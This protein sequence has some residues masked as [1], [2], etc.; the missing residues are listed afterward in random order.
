MKSAQHLR[1]MIVLVTMSALMCI[2]LIVEGN[3]ERSQSPHA[4][5]ADSFRAFRLTSSEANTSILQWDREIIRTASQRQ[6]RSTIEGFPL[7][8]DTA[9]D[10]IVEPFSV[11]GPA[12][13]FVLGRK[14]Q[15]D[16]AFSF[17]ATRI[18]FL[19]GK[20]SGQPNSHVFMAL[21][22]RQS[23]GYIDLG[24]GAGRY[25]IASRDNRGR[26]LGPGVISVF[27][28]L[29]TTSQ[30]PAVPFC[31]VQS[32]EVPD[33]NEP[34]LVGL[35]AARG[36]S[37][38]PGLKHIELAV[39][40]D[41]EYF[42]LFN[43][44]D[45]AATYLVQMYGA[46]SDIYI[47]DVDTRIELVFARLWDNPDD[48]FN[49]VDP[50]PLPEFQ[51]YWNANMDA[52]SRD[53]AQ[54]FSGRRDYPFGG[55]AFLSALCSSNGYSVVGYA[56]GFFPDPSMP[57]PFNYDIAV[58]AH[59]IAHN[60]G[61]A[62]THDPPNNI[63]TCNDPGTTPQ[64]GTIM[65]YCGQTWSG[66]N[67][68]R[69]LYFHTTIVQN[70]KDH[71]NSVA[72]VI[73]DCNMNGT[74]DAMDVM[75]T[76]PDVNGNGVPD[77][78][79]DCDDDG[80]LNDAEII[81]GSLDL[82]ANGIPDECEPDCNNNNIPDDKDIADGTSPD[83]YGN[84]IPD[85][86]EP[87]CDNDGTSDYT[88]IQFDM[89][90]DVDRNAVLDS[91]QDCD[92]DST[93]DHEA[94]NGSHNLW[95]ASGEVNTPVREFYASTGVLTKSSNGG[96]G[97]LVQRGQD[98]VIGPNRHVFVTSA[99]DDRVM[100]FDLDGNYLGDF[101]A[102]GI[103]GLDE[104][105]GLIFGPDDNLYVSSSLTNNVL[106]YNGTTGVFIDAFAS[107]GGLVTPFGLIFGRNGNLFVASGSNEVIEYDGQNGSFI[108]VFI[109]AADNGGL[110]Q[111]KGLTFKSDGN[112][113][114]CSFGTNETLEFDGETG[115][116]LGKW[117]QVGTETRL[118]QVSPWGI[119]VGPN[120]N[121]FIVR[122]G[123]DFGSGEGKHKHH[124]HIEDDI[125][126]GDDDGHGLHLT[127]AQIYEFDVRTG[128]FLRTHIG[129]NDHGLLFPT[130]FDFVP[131]WEIDCNL[132]LLPDGCDIASGFSQ[133]G[134]SNN[135]P[136]E[137]DIDC[138]NN[139]TLDRLDIIPFG[140]SFDCNGN[141][142]PDDCDIAAGISL[143][144]TGNGIPDEC[145]PDCNMNSTPDSCDIDGGGSSD[146]NANGIPDDCEPDC[147]EN[148]IPDACDIDVLDPDGNGMVSPDCNS[149]LV[150]DECDL[151]LLFIDESPE[152]SPIHNSSPQSHIIVSP[153]EA[154]SDA[155]LMFEAVADVDS[156]NETID[157]DI[158]GMPIGT[159]F[160]MGAAQCASTHDELIVPAAVFNAAVAGGDATVNLTASNL[161][162][163]LCNPTS[164][165]IILTFE[166]DADCN[167]NGLPDECDALMAGTPDCNGN[168]A[169]DDC[170]YPACLM[171]AAIM[172]G[173]FTCDL[174]VDSQDM[175]G[176]LDAMMLGANLCQ[177]DM[178]AD[179]QVNGEDIP[180]FVNCLLGMCP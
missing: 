126:H 105:T 138:N 116:P 69:D 146:C 68:N 19:R 139:D 59:E 179:M 76:S 23:T 6:G 31:G 125:Y 143:D 101:V 137:C 168:S 180:G 46:V 115:A 171:D 159:V 166:T 74:D 1:S 45:A 56:A 84:G 43:D 178:N 24:N 16:Q 63:D 177:A 18:S 100:E 104:P 36:V 124:D 93:I 14:G 22:D 10:L 96:P 164:I 61:T 108:R 120:G 15:P 97:A 173:D 13:R 32:H 40:T 66:Q 44:L 7:R 78:C 117:A 55:Q 118:T 91:C 5:N 149:N 151:T 65:S 169:P 122:T 102:P 157:V 112:L 64:R 176:F 85:E 67:S 127:N 130:G 41:F 161:V 121:V 12:T 109:S 103:G 17:D 163:N 30:V 141:L 3:G 160:V 54:L 57:S 58:A 165:E 150:P 174:V 26:A 48:L 38:V 49:D 107:G 156:I 83:L 25:Q 86:C 128:N 2:T 167:D 158:N 51:N 144:C 98:L 8:R 90:L 71:I 131:G 37:F 11:T 175:P 133:D 172:P 135:V 77:E 73:D 80:T 92:G 119:R 88:E 154:F 70:M 145:E 129:G 155:V 147:N 75:L 89:T 132:N 50:S 27:Q 47:R 134:D 53:I 110:D 113:L 29:S 79:E 28:S 35:A 136:D 34:A 72:C 39:E 170:D 140:I 81:G 153:P 42:S 111:P 60:A 148:T 62:H 82:N 152:L 142:S 33:T 87:D 9:V 162:G 114:V 106:R 94:L 52:V 123:E 21:C 4:K 95:I 99:D 20:V